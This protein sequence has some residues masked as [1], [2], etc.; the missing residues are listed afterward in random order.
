MVPENALKERTRAFE[1]QVFQKATSRQDY[2]TK[3]AEGL[4]NVERQAAK[5]ASDSARLALQN[6]GNPVTSTT[7]STPLQSN[8]SHQTGTSQ[9]DI[10][11]QQ[12]TASMVGQQSHPHQLHQSLESQLSQHQHQTQ[13]TQSQ[14]M[15]Q[16]PLQTQ[17]QQSARMHQQQ[18][19][20]QQQLQPQQQQQPQSQQA[21][22][23]SMQQHG[24]Q[25]QQFQQNSHQQS[26]YLAR[27]QLAKSQG[28]MPGTQVA[29][30]AAWQGAAQAQAQ[31]R[32]QLQSRGLAPSLGLN[33]AQFQVPVSG[34][35]TSQSHRGGQSQSNVQ[36]SGQMPPQANADL[37]SAPSSSGK[38]T[39]QNKD[40]KKP[41]ITRKITGN[42]SGAAAAAAAAAAG[43]VARNS[44]AFGAVGFSNAAAGANR[45]QQNPLG[46]GADSEYMLAL[47]KY[48]QQA[49]AP[50]QNVGIPPAA[51][52][53]IGRITRELPSSSSTAPSTAFTPAQWEQLAARL[54]VITGPSGALTS[55]QLQSLTRDQLRHLLSLSHQH[56]KMKTQSGGGVPSQSGSNAAISNAQPTGSTTAD[57]LQGAQRGQQ[58]LKQQLQA[59]PGVA[60]QAQ[61]SQ[62]TQQS[63][64]HAQQATS[65]QAQQAAQQHF[66][67]QQL[68]NRQSQLA[69]QRELS[70]Q[71]HQQST[72][73]SQFQGPSQGSPPQAQSA[74]QGNFRSGGGSG[75]QVL[76]NSAPP[77]AMQATGMSFPQGNTALE[78]TKWEKHD[79]TPQE[80]QNAMAEVLT[81]HMR[82]RAAQSGPNTGISP[83]GAGL[84]AQSS[85]S[86]RN[87][88]PAQ[89]QQVTVPASRRPE[90][91]TDPA[92]EE[93]WQRLEN[94]QRQYRYNL[95]KLLPGIK[96]L[97]ERQTPDRRDQFLKHVR[98]CFNILNMARTPVKPP[99]LTLEVLDR[100]GKFI[101]QVITVYSRPR[102]ASNNPATNLSHRTGGSG[103]NESL[104][105]ANGGDSSRQQLAQPLQHP[106]HSSQRPEAV[107]A[108]LV[109]QHQQPFL[110]TQDSSNGQTLTPQQLA[111]H[112]LQ[113]QQLTQHLQNSEAATSSGGSQ[114]NPNPLAAQLRQRIHQQ[115]LLQ[116][117]KRQKS[118][119]M[120]RIAANSESNT[121]P[122]NAQRPLQSQPL[123]KPGLMQLQQVPSFGQQADSLQ[124]G[125]LTS[126]QNQ[127]QSASQTSGQ[128]N[129]QASMGIDQSLDVSV[130]QHSH[131][132]HAQQNPSHRMATNTKSGHI[133]AQVQS[134]ASAVAGVEVQNR[135]GLQQGPSSQIDQKVQQA[136][137][138][139]DPYQSFV[140][141]LGHSAV[142][143]GSQ[144]LGR[145]QQKNITAQESS[146]SAQLAQVN[147]STALSTASF[148]GPPNASSANHLGATGVAKAKD[149]LPQRELASSG[150]RAPL[151]NRIIPGLSPENVAKLQAALQA[152]HRSGNTEKFN[153]L[154]QQITQ[155]INQ[156]QLAASTNKGAAGTASAQGSIAES[157]TGTNAP[158]SQAIPV[159]KAPDA[160]PQAPQKE[161][162]LAEK[163]SIM[164][165]AVNTAVEQ[166]HRLE[167]RLDGEMKRAKIERIQITLS[168]LRNKS[169]SSLALPGPIEDDGADGSLSSRKRPF[170]LVD[171]D[172]CPEVG[173]MIN[174]KTVFECST[175]MGLRLA[176]RPL[177]DSSDGKALKEAVVTDCIAAKDSQPIISY[178][179]LEE[180]GLPLVVC[181]LMIPEI[182]L[183]KLYLR[184]QRG[185]P[186]KGGATYGFERPALG[187]TGLLAEI[188]LRFKNSI[189]VAPAAVGVAAYLDAYAREASSVISK[190]RE[191]ELAC[192]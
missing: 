91:Q 59:P 101:T 9:S 149:T 88:S 168:A 146:H 11:L 66:I 137:P 130:Q 92:D 15:M 1:A 38:K 97:A 110:P 107:S 161:L 43:N 153:L 49:S 74:S 174:S 183:P 48:R 157:S 39:A 61:Q 3:I 145:T 179:I 115:Q 46:S 27:Q 141:Q 122:Q 167:S 50:Q 175:E 100:A 125:L 30:S 18:L 164:Q 114:L 44:S 65:R 159:A 124:G 4:C 78:N 25:Q 21:L 150:S 53:G 62:H 60:K 99:R 5:P 138:G 171:V 75:A 147:A 98:D 6:S 33:Q 32:N 166:S 189:A 144:Q 68:Q 184:I 111:Q 118:Q 151:P 142:D 186:R 2:L 152:A 190:L 105:D 72:Q 133:A 123:G 154:K 143:S 156:R 135:V 117:Q 12:S 121:F 17:S 129:S 131:L 20:L 63:Q 36:P 178:E 67:Q 191:G 120:A 47:S 57:D 77:V 106:S 136:A 14:Q 148:S 41:A 160:A 45:Y 109:G 84:S 23:H 87:N 35:N 112:N 180:F 182:R 104:A 172:H 108:T 16:T 26:L 76:S 79:A 81:Q 96:S 90:I 128:Q 94:M 140:G 134:T 19:Q 173:D 34:S 37:W 73:S 119:Q 31:I 58:A 10:G 83:G 113:Q 165:G 54:A 29:T 162:S 163:F 22:Q 102:E 85:A 89:A 24:L 86:V 139:Q 176:K 170:S 132:S 52:V 155:Y 51:S 158:A 192:C 103:Q 64:Q 69:R 56:Q 13:P 126:Q 93:F 7:T 82:D 28:Q 116:L 181:Q 187:W 55:A 8:P 177:G 185:Y 70:V 127:I 71:Q 188:H 40:Q 169:N 42:P 80:Q 95:Q